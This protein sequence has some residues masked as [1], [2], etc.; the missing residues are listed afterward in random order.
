MR[1][2]TSAAFTSAPCS[3]AN[4]IPSNFHYGWRGPPAPCCR[5]WFEAL[6]PPVERTSC[7]PYR[8]RPPAYPHQR[9][10]RV[11]RGR[12]TVHDLGIP[13]RSGLMDCSGIHGTSRIG[14]APCSK[15]TL[16]WRGPGLSCRDGQRRSAVVRACVHLSAMRHRNL[17]LFR[18][19][20]PPTSE[21]WHSSHWLIR[22]GALVE[23]LADSR[24]IGEHRKHKGR[25]AVG[26][27][28]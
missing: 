12:S 14:F 5:P 1:P 28:D 9:H 20:S 8:S 23:Q 26:R 10:W 3:T 6:S 15:E 11:R 18:D 27:A 19:R 4:L 24:C 2:S 13:G 22:I 25:R 7:N 17:R 21:P 16:R